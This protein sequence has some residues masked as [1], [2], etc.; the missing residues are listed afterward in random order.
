MMSTENHT[1]SDGQQEREP[2]QENRDAA[3]GW[4]GH[5]HF[6]DGPPLWTRIL[7][8]WPELRTGLAFSFV[9]L[10]GTLIGGAVAA[11]LACSGNKS[12]GAGRSE[13]QE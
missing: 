10:T 13:V 5:V 8:T 4:E 11:F 6:P 1:S 3:L 2:D 7:R 12:R 9:F